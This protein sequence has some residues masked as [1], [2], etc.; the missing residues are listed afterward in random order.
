MPCMPKSMLIPVNTQHTS[1]RQSLCYRCIIW[2]N[3]STISVRY[4]GLTVKPVVDSSWTTSV[5][6]GPQNHRLWVSFC[7]AIC[8]ISDVHG[9]HSFSTEFKTNYLKNVECVR[10]NYGISPYGL[11]YTHLFRFCTIS[12]LTSRNLSRFCFFHSCMTQNTTR[13]SRP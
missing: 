7:F 10:S 11:K 3:W 5:T 4:M 13:I 2:Q 1:S 6:N 9:S 8:I 12:F